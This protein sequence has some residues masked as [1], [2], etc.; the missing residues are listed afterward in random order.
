MRKIVCWDRNISFIN[1]VYHIIYDGGGL[2]MQS[3][4]ESYLVS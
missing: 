1:N 4:N 3:K 2:Y